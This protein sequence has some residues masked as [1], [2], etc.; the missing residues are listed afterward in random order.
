MATTF[1]LAFEFGKADV[2]EIVDAAGGK[3]N[4]QAEE[5]DGHPAGIVYRKAQG[6]FVGDR[7]GKA[8]EE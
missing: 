3:A 5:D 6:E 1:A 8:Q 4:S 2:Q 7:Q